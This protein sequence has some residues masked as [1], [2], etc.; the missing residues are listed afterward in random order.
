M[1]RVQ[2]RASLHEKA[3]QAVARGEVAPTPKRKRKAAQKPFPPLVQPAY[4]SPLVKAE[5]WAVAKKLLDN[6]NNY[7]SRWEVVSENEVIV[8]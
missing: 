2:Q 4:H 3:V 5:V 1:T 6:P 8:R 7:Y